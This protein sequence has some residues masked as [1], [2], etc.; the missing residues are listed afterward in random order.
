ML[1]DVCMMWS[2]AFGSYA[3]R[4]AKH[5]RTATHACTTQ[6]CTCWRAATRRSTSPTRRYVNRAP[7]D[8]CCTPTT[9][10]NC[11]IFDSSPRLGPAT[12]NTARGRHAPCR[13]VA[14]V[15]CCDFAISL[16]CA[17]YSL[18][19]ISWLE[20]ADKLLCCLGTLIL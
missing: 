16:C 19:A 7:T 12:G 10:P 11:A 5:T 20:R 13:H 14:K 17:L 6:S 9:P 4:T 3:T 2:T 8:P 15:W 1:P 18:F